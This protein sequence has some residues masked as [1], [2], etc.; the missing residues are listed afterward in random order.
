MNGLVRSVG[1]ISSTGKHVRCMSSVAF[2][3][4][5]ALECAPEVKTTVL[6]NGLRVATQKTNNAA[7]TVGVY[8]DAGSRFE[9]PGTN[10]IAN[11]VEH[12]I[13]K[14]KS[15]NAMSK[16]GGELGATTERE[17]TSFYA[18][19]SAS[20]ASDAVGVLG[21]CLQNTSFT[22]A[23]IA[24]AQTEVLFQM[25]AQDGDK[26]TAVLDLLHSTAFQGTAL[27]SSVVGPTANVR[28]F[29]KADVSAYIKNNFTAPRMVL[30]ASGN[31]DHDSIVK[32]AE[33]ALGSLPSEE[34]IQL[35]DP[36]RFTGSAVE[37]RDDEQSYCYAGIALEGVGSSHPDYF[38]LAVA[39]EMIGQWDSSFSFAD[40]RG[41]ALTSVLIEDQSAV[42]LKSFNI[43]YSNTGLWGCYFAAP[44]LKIDDVFHE[45]QQEWMKLCTACPDVY[46]E[47][48]KNALKANMLLN[49]E[50]ST[51]AADD[52]GRQML[53]YGRVMSKNEIVSR[54][55]AVTTADVSA[56]LTKYIYDQCPAVASIGQTEAVPDYNRIR[57]GQFWLRI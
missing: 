15:A 57:S 18:R 49:L 37:Y 32:A 39:S 40:N 4:Q 13:F 16:V 12:L 21:G 27:A 42:V 29:G 41:S 38:S 23:D 22:D 53:A 2:S 17:M 5:N 55:D 34:G 20:K 6:G 8:V 46:T 14:G 35:S 31:V 3:Y 1:S 7:A 54:I 50:S 44:G 30:A 11:F 9:T 56:T 25:N 47:R 33:A 28:T 19:T 43:S 51:A 26:E 48:A 36:P 52:I 10:G 24:S 45:V